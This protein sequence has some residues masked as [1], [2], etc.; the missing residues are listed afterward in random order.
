M[1]PVLV[2]GILC[3]TI[4]LIFCSGCTSSSPAPAAPATP[5]PTSLPLTSTVATPVPTATPYP[6]A[7][8]LN[9]PA[10]FGMGPRTG[11]ATVYKVEV[12]SNYNYTTSSWGS[13]HE[14]S[15]AGAPFGIQN[16]YS[17]QEPAAGNTF[18]FVYVRLTDT[19]T[20][21]LTAP[22]PKQFIVNYDGK[23]YPYSPVAGSD[24]TVNSIYVPQYDYAIGTGGVAGSL[25]P[26]DSNAVAGYLIYE[27]PATID[28]TKAV[29]VIALDQ[30]NQ[31]AW[32]LA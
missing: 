23:D 12:R 8:A 24:V 6:G 5:V 21:D 31:A 29:L 22:S 3:I 18:L 28:L 32:A 15:Q 1:K 4:A 14:Q 13:A 16:G 11:M 10:T 20:M 27:V 25:L 30:D 9:Q 2:L 7:L 26:G 19:G 17:T